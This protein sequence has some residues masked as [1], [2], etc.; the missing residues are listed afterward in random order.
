MSVFSLIQPALNALGVAPGELQL[1]ETGTLVDRYY[2]NLS[3]DRPALIGVIKGGEQCRALARLLCQ[4]YPRG[5]T[6][7]VVHDLESQA[8]RV[9][10]IALEQLGWARQNEGRALLYVPALLCPGATETFQDV[11]AHL[12]APDGCPWDRRQ[13][14]RSLREGFLEEAYEVLDALDR[15]DIELLKEELGDILL[16]VL[17]QVQIASELGEFQMAD[18]VCHVHRKIVYRHPH[19]F[20]GLEVSGV[21]EVLVNWEELKQREK[22]AGE[23]TPSAL[24]SIS[25]TMPALARAQSIQRHVDRTGVLDTSF[26]KL[27]A[28]I[29]ARLVALSN[30]LDGAEQEGLLGDLLFEVSDLARKLGV[31]AESALREVNLRFETRYR[32]LEQAMGRD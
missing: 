11:V 5:H 29:S 8:P 14:H 16:H 28:G 2:P 17:L 12:R 24:D 9:E 3:P 31:D 30:E 23:E 4:A 22:E 21:A 15:G 26:N 32:E 19:V 27:V 6:V 20:A 7:Q 1:V 25:P 13:T 18:V 10:S